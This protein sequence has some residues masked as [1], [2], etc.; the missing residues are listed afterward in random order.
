MSPTGSPG[1]LRRIARSIGLSP[2]EVEGVRYRPRP[3]RASDVRVEYDARFPSGETMRIR[4]TD[5]RRYADVDRV[6]R[7]P[8]SRLLESRLRPGM[9]VLDLPCGTG[10]TAS[11][12]AHIVGPSGAVIAL[13]TDGESIRYA[14]R[15]YHAPHLG[16][17]I[18][19]TR[20]L[21]GELPDAFDA[22]LGPPAET[23]DRQAVETLVRVLTTPGWLLLPRIIGPSS[24]D[25]SLVELIR[26]MVTSDEDDGV[27]V[28]LIRG[29]DPSLSGVLVSRI[30]QAEKP[31]SRD[32]RG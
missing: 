1:L 4:C 12:L 23:A 29:R 11:W 8:A 14:R 25:A 17:E 32:E 19:G 16:Y 22:I 13:D 18:G 26:G 10:A 31:D 24:E 7:I 28:S 3:R 27:S 21:A 5:N 15:R 30:A 9:R 20:D 2:I 6:P